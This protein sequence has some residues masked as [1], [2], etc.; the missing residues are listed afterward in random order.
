MTT[1][2][3]RLTAAECLRVLTEENE[4]SD[5]DETNEG[6]NEYLDSDAVENNEDEENVT[7]DEEESVNSNEEDD[8]MIPDDLL[9]SFEYNTSIYCMIIV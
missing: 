2:R 1:R 7:D 9:V 3:R 6:E 4:S 8:R 5:E